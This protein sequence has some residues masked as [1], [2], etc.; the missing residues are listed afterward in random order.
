ML[1]NLYNLHTCDEELHEGSRLI[2]YRIIDPL[3][4]AREIL[5]SRR[6][7]STNGILNFSCN[8]VTSASD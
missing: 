5:F 3:A 4:A 1:V 8:I 7:H 6:V 2:N